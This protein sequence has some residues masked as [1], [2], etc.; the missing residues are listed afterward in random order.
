M[1]TPRSAK[2]RITSAWIAVIVLGAVMVLTLKNIVVN[3]IVAYCFIYSLG[4]ITGII[5]L[6]LT[7]QSTEQSNKEKGG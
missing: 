4:L 1:K 6:R 5:L 7:R 3:P 2:V